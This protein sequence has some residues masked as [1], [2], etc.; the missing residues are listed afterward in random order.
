M[1]RQR[2][3]QSQGGES[4]KERDTQTHTQTHTQGDEHGRWSEVCL[5]V[6]RFDT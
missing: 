1:E 5:G 6:S 4:E 2:V 3:T